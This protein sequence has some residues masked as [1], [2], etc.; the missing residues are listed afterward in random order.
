MHCSAIEEE[1]QSLSK[2]LLK[3]FYIERV[4][5]EAHARMYSL[6]HGTG[7]L[8]RSGLLEDLPEILLRG[9]DK[10]G[11]EVIGDCVEMLV[12][13][14]SSKRR[15]IIGEP[16]SG[17]S[18]MFTRMLQRDQPMATPFFFELK[19]FCLDDSTPD[20]VGKILKKTENDMS[21]EF[22]IKPYSYQ[23]EILENLEAE[24]EIFGRYK[25]L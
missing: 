16:G 25:N 17:K 4:H 2:K 8:D 15:L 23:K 21:F 5:K 9:K 11:N 12:E 6:F 3:L 18:V 10:D 22:D 19:D 13:N 1:L 24:R 14:Q 20:E 7:I